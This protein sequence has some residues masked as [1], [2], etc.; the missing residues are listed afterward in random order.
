MPLT[1]DLREELLLLIEPVNRIRDR[2]GLLSYD[3]GGVGL[4]LIE[5]VR[6]QRALLENADQAMEVAEALGAVPEE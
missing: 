2:A 3:Q 5:L 4:S 1:P 6:L